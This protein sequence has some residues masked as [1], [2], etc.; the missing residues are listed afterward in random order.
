[1]SRM[2]KKTPKQLDTEI[3]EAIAAR[4]RRA[5]YNLTV[6]P[7]YSSSAQ[8]PTVSRYIATLSG[9][10]GPDIQFKR[11]TRALAVQAA[12]TH[13]DRRNIE[14]DNRKLVEARQDQGM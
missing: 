9:L 10:H 5:V 8:M 7:V 3:A 14:V 11:A 2:A 4:P 13:A 1:M 12:L 6:R